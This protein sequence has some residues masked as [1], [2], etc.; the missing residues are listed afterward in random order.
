MILD[1]A[2][3]PEPKS[4]PKGGGPLFV[5]A[6]GRVA[7]RAIYHRDYFDNHPAVIFYNPPD[8]AI[9]VKPLVVHNWKGKVSV[10]PWGWGL[11]MGP[12]GSC[13][14]FAA[15]RLTRD[16]P[17]DSTVFYLHGPSAENLKTTSVKSKVLKERLG[18]AFSSSASPKPFEFDG[19]VVLGARSGRSFHI[20]RPIAKDGQFDLQL[21]VSVPAPNL[22][23]ATLIQ[24][25][26]NH[27][28]FVWALRGTVGF[29][30]LDVAKALTKDQLRQLVEGR[31]APE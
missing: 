28:G 16:S 25:A 4:R 11:V 23:N 19:R 2:G 20:T 14:L 21:V 24:I 27:I 5:F 22:L 29:M 9:S 31:A 7:M 6:D 13:D 12:R 8:H 3:R 26:K 1:Y 10:R 18:R 30:K 17:A 15:V